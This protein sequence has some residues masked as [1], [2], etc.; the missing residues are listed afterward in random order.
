MPCWA[1]EGEEV[2]W[3][4]QDTA[5]GESAPWEEESSALALEGEAFGGDFSAKEVSFLEEL[6]GAFEEA[7]EDTKLVSALEEETQLVWEDAGKEKEDEKE[8]DFYALLNIPYAYFYAG[9][10]VLAPKEKVEKDLPGT[11]KRG[12]YASGEDMGVCFPVKLSGKEK[13]ILAYLES[14]ASVFTQVG[15]GPVSQ[16]EGRELLS[17]RPSFSFCFLSEEP[18]VYKEVLLGEKIGLG[19][20][21]GETAGPMEVTASLSLGKTV[22]ALFSMHVP[23]EGALEGAIPCGVV[24]VDEEGASYGFYHG[25]GIFSASEFGFDMGEQNLLN[26]TI[27]QMRL[28]TAE[29]VYVYEVYIHVTE[30]AYVLMNVPYEEF[31]QAELGN[32]PLGEL[33]SVSSPSFTERILAGEAKGAYHVSP[34]GEDVSGVTYPVLVADVRYL[35]GL[36]QITEDTSVTMGGKTY[37]GREALSYAPSYSYY[38]LEER[39]AVRKVLLEDQEGG[40]VFSSVSGK[41]LYAEGLTGETSFGGTEGDLF[42]T[43]NPTGATLSLQEQGGEALLEAAFSGAVLTLDDG[44]KIGFR[45]LANTFG[46]TRLGLRFAE[47]S[48]DILGRTVTGVTYYTPEMVVDFP[49][50][51]QIP[52]GTF[53]LMNLPYGKF[54]EAELPAGSIPDGVSSATKGTTLSYEARRGSFAPKGGEYISEGTSFPVL[55][56]EEALLASLQKYNSEEELIEGMAYGYLP[57]T[58]KPG[59]CKVFYASG[60]E[61]FFGPVSSHPIKI[62][63]STTTATYGG[64]YAAATLSL[65]EVSAPQTELLSGGILTNE[66][67]EMIPLCHLQNLWKGTIG[68]PAGEERLLGKRLTALRI[69]TRDGVWEYEADLHLHNIVKRDGREPTF[70]AQGLR[71]HYACLS[72]GR[73]YLNADATTETDG[74]DLIIPMLKLVRAKISSTMERFYARTLTVVFKKIAGATDYQL[75]VRKAGE[76]NYFLKTKTGGELSYKIEDLEDGEKLDIKVRALRKEKKKGTAKGSYSKIHRRWVAKPV[77][78]AKGKEN[79]AKLSVMVPG[80]AILLHVTFTSDEKTIERDK[81][82]TATKERLKTITFNVKK[83][84]SGTYTVRVR[85]YAQVGDYKYKSALSEDAEVTVK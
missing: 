38:R 5:L 50:N 20:V 66:E 29:K 42:F 73:L 69:Y 1:L 39:P 52:E 60:G 21:M 56:A 10:G 47:V 12:T 31:Y 35:D 81:K 70:F 71:E 3:D 33:K 77:V 6:P 51:I 26:K 18:A 59:L 22:D 9:E 54:Y 43:L 15:T 55:V 45:H 58:G 17:G 44:R 57:L 75:A 48:L 40:K 14:P 24:L 23:E 67:G 84:S 36:N 30:F 37:A 72:C 7:A 4:G 80:D 74:Q 11:D 64:N 49:A 76:P 28:I 78:E 61:F 62:W 19:P 83:L 34:E 13:E 46:K 79:A 32:A 16:K 53:V 65:D 41:R 25:E 8:K 63:G 82:L 85:A 68:I 27:R 2:S